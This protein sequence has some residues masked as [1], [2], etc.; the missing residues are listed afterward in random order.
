MEFFDGI[1]DAFEQGRQVPERFIDCGDEILVFVRSEA[2]ARTTDL[3]IN[4]PW[5][6]LITVRDGKIVRF[7]QF[8]SRAEALE[9][10]GLEE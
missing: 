7:E 6:H 5:A 10:A 2:R 4:E 3:E 1:F 9:A 8:R